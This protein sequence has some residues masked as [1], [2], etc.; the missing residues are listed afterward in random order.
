MR[1]ALAL[2]LLAACGRKATIT[3]EACDQRAD[4]IEARSLAQSDELDTL[5]MIET[6]VDPSQTNHPYV[7]E[8]EEASTDFAPGVVIPISVDK[9]AIIEAVAASEACAARE[10]KRPVR[11]YLSAPADQDAAVAENAAWLVRAG[12]AWGVDVSARRIVHLAHERDVHAW[13]PQWATGQALAKK[14]NGERRDYDAIYREVERVTRGCDAVSKLLADTHDNERAGFAM[15]D[16]L[17]SCGCRV[18]NLD[19]AEGV[20]QAMFS[21]R[22]QLGWIPPPDGTSTRS[23]SPLTCEDA[24]DPMIVGTDEHWRDAA[25]DIRPALIGVLHDLAECRDAVHFPSGVV[26]VFFTGG[27]TAMKVQVISLS[28]RGLEL[29]ACMKEKPSHAIE[30]VMPTLGDADLLVYLPGATT[31]AP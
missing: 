31:R 11:L 20:W 16:G 24:S 28:P 9:P 19:E 1:A 17:R 26:H 12:K 7:P 30:L 27:D 14:A 2:V 10:T 22:T 21:A 4:A 25:P 3:K 23:V 18:D 8:A 13:P 29:A 6:F 15:P 5:M